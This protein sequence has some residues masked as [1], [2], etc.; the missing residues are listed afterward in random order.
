VTEIE[1]TVELGIVDTFAWVPR[2]F[3][4]GARWPRI[5]GWHWSWF[6]YRRTEE[7]V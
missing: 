7:V 2:R 1:V 3:S 6:A 4:G 5:R